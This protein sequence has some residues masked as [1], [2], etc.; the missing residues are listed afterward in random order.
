MPTSALHVAYRCLS[1]ARVR[2]SSPGRYRFAPEAVANRTSGRATAFTRE[3]SRLSRVHRRN[4]ECRCDR[5]GLMTLVSETA[6][7]SADSGPRAPLLIGRWWAKCLCS[8]FEAR[9][10]E[11]AGCFSCA[12]GRAAGVAD[13]V[14]V[15][16]RYPAELELRRVCVGGCRC[17]SLPG[18]CLVADRGRRA[19][20]REHLC[21]GARRA[22][23]RSSRAVDATIALVAGASGVGLAPAIVSSE[24]IEDLSTGLVPGLVVGLFVWG[25]LRDIA[26]RPPTW[27]AGFQAVLIVIVGLL[28]AYVGA[29]VAA[30]AK[31]SLL[32]VIGVTTALLV[33]LLL[34]SLSPK[35]RAAWHSIVVA[36]GFTAVL[37][38][39][40]A[41]LMIL[42]R[43]HGPL[44]C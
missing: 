17:R 18:G 12:R 19:R 27:A 35:T 32:V 7:R 10:W 28:L 41:G 2:E 34:T 39:P 23:G 20:G 1:T 13:R 30:Y 4:H 9:R 31:A 42:S 37:V 15:C 22:R 8:Q 24:R 26:A 44:S 6:E 14:Q 40:A 33:A 25:A 29:L 36:A 5:I 11:C 3:R 16:P 43:G 38:V 21:W